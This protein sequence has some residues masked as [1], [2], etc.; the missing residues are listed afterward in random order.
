MMLWCLY[1]WT[2]QKYFFLVFSSNVMFSW[3][4]Y[5][6]EEFWLRKNLLAIFFFSE[7]ICW[8]FFCSFL[9]I[10]EKIFSP[11]NFDWRLIP[12]NSK[13]ENNDP[14]FSHR[15]QFVQIEL[16]KSWAQKAYFQQFSFLVITESSFFKKIIIFF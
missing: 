2:P 7:K 3:S 5:Y 13:G 15:S 4:K 12:Y 11:W 8:Q 1:W 9:K 10:M 14:Y 6:S 16:K